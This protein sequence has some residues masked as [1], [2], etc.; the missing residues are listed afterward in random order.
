MLYTICY[1][2]EEAKTQCLNKNQSADVNLEIY[3]VWG[4]CLL[5]RSG[6]FT[7]IAHKNKPL[8]WGPLSVFPSSAIV[9]CE[10]SGGD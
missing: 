2:E 1:C 6:N 10:N 3:S 5:V 7:V 4:M 9:R 8:L